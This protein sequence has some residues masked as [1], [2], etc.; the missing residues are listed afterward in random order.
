M[1]E[2][3]PNKN[4]NLR[5]C[6]VAYGTTNL[7]LIIYADFAFNTHDFMQ[8]QNKIQFTSRNCELA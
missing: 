2:R 5:N 4:I 3:K 6:E 8:G 1:W 7:D